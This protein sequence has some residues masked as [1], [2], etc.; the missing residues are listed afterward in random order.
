MCFVLA[1]TFDVEDLPANYKF[2]YRLLMEK[3]YMANDFEIVSE[4]AAEP[5]INGRVIFDVSE[6]MEDAILNEF[7]EPPVPE[8]NG[9]TTYVNPAS[10]RFRIEY[11]ERFGQPPETQ[12]Y[13]D[14]DIFVAFLGGISDELFVKGD[15]FEGLSAGSSYLTWWPNRKRLGPNQPDYLTWMNYTEQ[16]QSINMRVEVFKDGQ[17][18]IEEILTRHNAGVVDEDFMI[19]FPVGPAQLDLNSLG[20]DV[21]MY[22]VQV[23]NGQG[24]ALSPKRTYTVDQMPANPEHF[25]LYFNG[26]FQPQVIRCLGQR[27]QDLSINRELTSRVRRCEPSVLLGNIFQSSSDFDQEFLYRTGYLKRD[28]MEALQELLIYSN[29]FE[30][31][32]EGYRSLLVMNSRFS[33]GNDLDILRAEEI[34][35]VGSLKKKAYSEDTS[36]RIPAEI[37]TAQNWLTDDEHC[38]TE[39]LNT[40]WQEP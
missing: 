33:V 15:F 11:A 5:D 35:T 3:T 38:W 39:M 36:G 8:F 20:Y 13:E 7:E 18:V 10:R 14:S 4:H 34:Q 27:R 9:T 24:V 29:V 28:E 22:T 16:P 12:D 25:L 30:I 19:V 26:F 31:T 32:A 40:F 21:S 6:L 1:T 37:C 23:F 2:N 17:M